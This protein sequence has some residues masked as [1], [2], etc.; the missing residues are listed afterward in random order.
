MTPPRLLALALSAALLAGCGVGF[1]GGPQ[2]TEFF[3]S[4]TVT[5]HKQTGAPLT[6]AV[7]YEQNYPLDVPIQCEL[8]RGKALIKLIGGAT[9]PPYPDG[10]PEKTPFPGNFSFDFTVEEAGHYKVQC[11]TTADDDNFIEEEF[12]VRDP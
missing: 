4:L 1:A 12:D 3:K 7:T 5:G 8:R 11:Y 10:T 6:A 9:A 2:G